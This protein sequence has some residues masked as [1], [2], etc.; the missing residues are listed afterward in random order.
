M[1][2]A[3]HLEMPDYLGAELLQMEF[4]DVE[5]QQE[6]TLAEASIEQVR[7]RVFGLGVMAVMV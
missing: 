3:R 7:V 1:Q 6:Q 4:C 2:V 5:L